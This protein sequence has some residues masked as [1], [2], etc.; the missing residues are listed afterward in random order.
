MCVDNLLL[1]ALYLSVYLLA[2]CL[3]YYLKQSASIDSILLGNCV[4][5]LKQPSIKRLVEK[6]LQNNVAVLL[7]VILI[8]FVPFFKLIFKPKSQPFENYLKQIFVQKTVS[9]LSQSWVHYLASQK[10]YNFHQQ[11]LIFFA[12]ILQLIKVAF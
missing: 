2:E 4:Q 11:A 10:P 3:Q 12:Q 5:E 6:L 8:I 1:N 7:C 9:K